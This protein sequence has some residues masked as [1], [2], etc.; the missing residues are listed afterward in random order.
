MMNIPLNQ[1]KKHLG[2]RL[3]IATR[4]C[5]KTGITNLIDMAGVR[6]PLPV[7]RWLPVGSGT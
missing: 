7:C 3:S 6:E 4:F 2:Y 1:M 5:T